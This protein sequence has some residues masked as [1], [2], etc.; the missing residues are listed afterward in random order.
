[1]KLLLALGLHFRL[2]KLMAQF[3]MEVMHHKFLP[4]HVREIMERT[5]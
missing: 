2:V 5:F 1:M 4:L 3:L